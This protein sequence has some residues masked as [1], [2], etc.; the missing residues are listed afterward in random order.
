M[1]IT[2]LFS[3]IDY[4]SVHAPNKIAVCNSEKSLTYKKL[5]EQTLFW[6]NILLPYVQDNKNVVISLKDTLLFIQIYSAVLRLNRIPIVIDPFYS[7]SNCN[8]FIKQDFLFLDESKLNQLTFKKTFLHSMIIPESRLI[9]PGIGLLTSG[10]TGEKKLAIL[11]QNNLLYSIKNSPIFLHKRSN[12]KNILSYLPHYHLAGFYSSF[13]MPFLSGGSLYLENGMFNPQNILAKIHK[14]SISDILIVPAVLRTLTQLKNKK[15]YNKEIV[16]WLGGDKTHENDLDLA[17]NIFPKAVFFNCYAMTEA[18][19]ISCINITKYPEKIGSVGKAA[20][21]LQIKI[22]NPAKA[23]VGEI[24]IK[25]PS[26]MLRYLN[27]GSLSKKWFATG[28]LG[29]LDNKK[30]LYLVGRKKNIIKY[31]GFSIFPET[32][33]K[34]ILNLA[35]VSQCV[36]VGCDHPLLGQYPVAAVVLK[37]TSLTEKSIQNFCIGK[38]RDFEIPKRVLFFKK[39]PAGAIGKI[40]RSK[41]FDLVLEQLNKEKLSYE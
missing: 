37:K 34:I 27:S 41:T 35:G 30:F 9:L 6:A 29:Y 33:E 4:Q 31:S 26:V 1:K 17:K 8:D 7:A 3:V 32:I 11:S 10:T 13:L 39:L 24:L 16:I 19:R 36:V 12:S 18:P 28:D 15:P 5:K 23:E 40:S 38:A 20:K 2:S 14:Y 25:G 22:D 21:G